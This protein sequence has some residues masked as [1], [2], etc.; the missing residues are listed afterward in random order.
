MIIFI[1]VDLILT[2]AVN[3]YTTDKFSQV[4]SHVQ[5]TQPTSADASRADVGNPVSKRSD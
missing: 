2:V 5:T 4:T 3:G 1:G